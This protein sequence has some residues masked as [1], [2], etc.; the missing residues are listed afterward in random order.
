MVIRKSFFICFLSVTLSMFSQEADFS[1]VW[2]NELATALRLSEGITDLKVK[3]L[4]VEQSIAG[5]TTN[6][7]FTPF[8]PFTN[9]LTYCVF[10][11]S[12]SLFSFTPD[13]GEFDSPTV[14]HVFPLS[15]ELPE[16]LLKFYLVF[17]QPMEVGK[18][19]DHLHL[20]QDEEELERAFIRL[21]PELWDET[22]QQLTVWIEPGRIKR[23]LGPNKRLGPVLEA[24]KTYR[25]VLDEEF[26][27]RSG[28][29]LESKLEKRFVVAERDEEIPKIE[30]VKFKIP[31]KH[32]NI[33]LTVFFDEPMDYATST[34]VSIH[35]DEERI[36]GKWNMPRDDVLTFW[37]DNNWER[38][39]Y[40]LEIN[41]DSEDLAGN[42][43][44]R[45]FDVDLTKSKESPEL[46][47][48]S[49]KFEIK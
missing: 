1:L 31:K 33:P 2:E 25:L 34:M 18:V 48:V 11:G 39:Y 36:P 47:K 15:G 42:N 8:V 13:I 44:I 10:S 20:F 28:K 46:E 14:D 4:G 22:G 40:R 7:M 24:G 26:R 27:S 23:D 43:F 41:S 45:L 6:D 5:R 38:G 16:N 49:A 17:S 9:G 30:S 32:T 19:Y 3:L 21:S 35:L 29:A 12:D 37:P